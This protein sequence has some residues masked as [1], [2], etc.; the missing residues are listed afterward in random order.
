MGIRTVFEILSPRASA[1]HFVCTIII[2]FICGW[3]AKA[4]AGG[5]G[6]EGGGEGERQST[7]L[8]KRK[9]VAGVLTPFIPKNRLK[10][11]FLKTTV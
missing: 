4:R 5:G 1:S 8:E 7:M 6:G 2:H 10:L 11:L 3:H 9:K